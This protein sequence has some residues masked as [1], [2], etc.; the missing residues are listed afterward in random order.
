MEQLKLKQLIEEEKKLAEEFKSLRYLGNLLIGRCGYTITIDPSAETFYFDAKN[1]RIVISLRLIKEGNLT[2]LEKTFVF[3]HETAHVSQ[4]FENPEEYLGTFEIARREAEKASK[5]Q[6]EEI[7]ISNAWNFYF[8]IILDI[9]CNALVRGRIPVFQTDLGRKS[10]EE[11]YCKI[12]PITDLQNLSFTEQFLFALLIK[13]MV[14]GREL[15]LSDDVRKILEQEIIYLGKRYHSLYE[16]VR[17]N[18]HSPDA[19]L[20]TILLRSRKIIEPIFRELLEKDLENNR[21][22]FQL[23]NRLIEFFDKDLPKD[24]LEKIAKDHKESQKPLRDRIQERQSQM[25]EKRLAEAGF[26]DEEIQQILEIMKKV[27]TVWQDLMSLW[28]SIVNT[29][30][31]LEIKVIS[32]FR[33]GTG[34]DIDALIR[35]FYKLYVQP[36]ELRI[37]T[38]RFL[39]AIKEVHKPK[40]ISLYLILDLS[41]SMDANKRRSVQE[42]AYCLVKSLIQT[43]RKAQDEM[44]YQDEFSLQAN[45]RVIGF[46]SRY[47]DL[48]ERNQTEIIKR[49][50][51]DSD[52]D[53]T[54][55]RIWEMVF[56]I[57]HNNLGGTNDSMPLMEVLRE[58]QREDV[59]KALEAD[60]EIV[61]VIEITDGETSTPNESK[62]ILQQ[63]QQLP[64]VFPRAI[65]IKGSITSEESYGL[66]DQEKSVGSSILPPTGIFAEVWGELGKEL[67][68]ITVLKE[69]LLQILSDLFK[70]IKGN[71]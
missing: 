6:Q 22:D 20:K 51:D 67:R 31:V 18:L 9:H 25:I 11:L 49:K 57:Q 24:V 28:E 23:L 71:E 41:G 68:D 8:N 2:E 55:K 3:L 14:P 69:L 64:N 33:S 40:K 30:Q 21:T 38:R 19:S 43:I 66:D 61:L 53:L 46:G 10:I 1:R 12:F 58:L 70:K 60:E 44:K 54:N 65:Q 62:E 50:I 34:I 35:Q 47:E 63:L 39:E 16:F 45:I 52:R 42:V 36:S 13:T 5:G 4:L 15:G 29:S 7:F 59:K 56:K 37:F 27:E 17:T 32:G 26:N 48:L